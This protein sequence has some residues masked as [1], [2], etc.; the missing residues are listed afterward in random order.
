MRQK[1]GN[2]RSA[3]AVLRPCLKN[4]GTHDCKASSCVRILRFEEELGPLG[5]SFHVMFPVWEKARDEHCCCFTAVTSGL[6][7]TQWKRPGQ[8]AL[9]W[10]DFFTWPFIHTVNI[11]K[12]LSWAQHYSAQRRLGLVDLMSR[13]VGKALLGKTGKGA[14]RKEGRTGVC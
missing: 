9:Q 10:T 1:I 11:T 14:K 6:L 2:W 7:A 13:Q 12:H 3:W 4:K 5:C 8:F